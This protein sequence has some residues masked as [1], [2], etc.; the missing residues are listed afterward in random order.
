MT[1][2]KKYNIL[3]ITINELDKHYQSL[4]ALI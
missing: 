3:V 2:L 1:Q 4:K